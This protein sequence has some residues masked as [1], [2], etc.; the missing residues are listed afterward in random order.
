MILSREQVEQA[1]IIMGLHGQPICRDTVTAAYRLLAKKVHPD[2]GGDA[3]QFA[4]LD[5]AKHLLLAYIEKAG[6]EAPSGSYKHEECPACKGKGY[7]ALR[8][9]FGTL[10]IVCNRCRGSG[11]A[12]WEPDKVET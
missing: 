9:H 5:R 8:R 12:R 7:V 2:A 10:S 3:A 6:S 1:Q 4:A 11:D